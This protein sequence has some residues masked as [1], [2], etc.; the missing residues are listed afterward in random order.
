VNIED[1]SEPLIVLLDDI[2]GPITACDPAN[3]ADGDIE[4]EV[5][6]SEH[7]I[8]SWYNGSSIINPADSIP[9]FNNS[10]EINNLVPGTY[11]VWVMDTLSGC[12]TTR[13][14]SIEG[15]EVPLV[16][17]T[18]SN[19]YSSCIQ[20]DGMVAAQVSG[21]SGEYLYTWYVND[22]SGIRQLD[23][24]NNT[25]YVE[26]LVS[27]TYT[28]SVQDALEP[29][30]EEAESQVVVEDGRGDEIILTVHNDLQMT[31][32]DEN[33]PNGQLSVEVN[34]ELSRFNFF[35]YAGNGSAGQPI[36][37]GPV[38]GELPAGDYTVVAR[39]RVSGCISNAFY[40][41]VIAQPDT[42][43]IPAPQVSSTPVDRC[44]A[45][46]GSA[47]ASLDSTMIDPN[48][49]YIFTWFDN[50]GD[51]IFSSSRHPHVNFLAAGN[52]SVVATNSLSGCSS[53]PTPFTINEEIYIPEFELISTSSTCLEDNGTIMI[54]F[55]EPM[56]VV[57]VEWITPNGYASGFFLSNQPPGY[58][59]VNVTDD[60][61]CVHTQ[62]GVILSNI[63]AYNGVSPNGDGRNDR[64]IISC[65]EQYDENRVQIYNRAGALVYENQNYD[66]ES[67]YFEGVGNRGLYIGGEKLP[68]GTYYYIIDKNNG[69]EPESG[70]LE[71]L[72]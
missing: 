40:G 44:D 72:R 27:G 66:N 17:T 20:P 50:E 30:C 68:E 46:N 67:V 45:P 53:E 14:Y 19:S 22:A 39:D 28:V 54:D 23:V 4:V 15:I 57:D 1:N 13:T 24:P 43:F 58:Y 6:N 25:S 18:S 8:T 64:F 71:L 33:R 32:C 11:T 34:G 62:S 60:K 61:G 41:S 5:R 42:T 31:N 69:E 16:V 51:E 37:S 29:Y 9:G 65:I 55:I 63:H 48:V 21:G 59:E 36:A 49:D 7:F 12:S 10:L 70:F 26:G 2:S 56:R 35:W 52:Y 3:F 47:A 38:A